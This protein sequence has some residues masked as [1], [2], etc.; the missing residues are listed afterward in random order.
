MT[1]QNLVSLHSA[2]AQRISTL[3][4][5]ALW[6]NFTVCPFALYTDEVIAL[7]SHCI[8][9]NPKFIGNTTI[10]FDGEQIAI[11][12]IPDDFQDDS[13][14]LDNLSSGIVHEMFHA[15]QVICGDTR[16]PND[17]K[18]MCWKPTLQELQMKR[19]EIFALVNAVT[20]PIVQL[21]EESLVHFAT[22][23][24]ERLKLADNGL[25]E[26]LAIECL[27]GLA[28]YVGMK[29]LRQ[30]NSMAWEEKYLKHLETCLYE[31]THLSPRTSGY[32]SGTLFFMLLERFKL[33][34]TLKTISDDG[35]TTYFEQIDW[36]RFGVNATEMRL[37]NIYDNHLKKRQLAIE[38]FLANDYA[39]AIFDGT[40]VGYD[41]IN[42]TRH[43]DLLLCH[44][45]V[46]VKETDEI[47]SNANSSPHFIKG[48]VLLSM[49]KASPN[50]ILGYWHL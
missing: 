36:Q 46:M 48:P 40:I 14:S 35:K 43:D 13:D 30:L 29:A 49:K 28:E 7:D 27:E 15:F 22:A 18:L 2:I 50:S 47:A 5:T 34:D 23:R 1:S 8:P 11:W 3:D 41:P 24:F 12:N 16:Y 31:D 25:C 20:Q 19:A 33:I 10:E 26:E 37:A 45:F 9:H 4:F 42:T 39:Y 32:A 6:P 38:Q 17:L 21:A 44:H